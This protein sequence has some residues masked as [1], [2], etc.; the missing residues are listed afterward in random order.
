MMML[1]HVMAGLFQLTLTLGLAI[2]AKAEDKVVNV[3]NWGR[4]TSI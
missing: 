1:R 4:T 3:Y 2:G